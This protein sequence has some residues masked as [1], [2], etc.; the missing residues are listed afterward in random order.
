MRD[1]PLRVYADTSVF[2]GAF[3]EEFARASQEFFAQVRR[4]RFHLVTSAIVQREIEL[5]PAEVR[6]LFDEMAGQG[7][8]VVVTPE[9]IQLQQ[10]YIKTGIVTPKS[11]ADALHVAVATVSKCYLIVSWNFKHIVH[12]EKIPL[13]NAV[14]IL[15]KQ[16]EIAIYSP[17]GVIEDEDKDENV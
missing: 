5:A 3:D 6:N 7:E 12:F 9:A 13:Y 1:Q 8:I 14:N 10:A 15:N 16:Q 2:G 11:A 4:G 17:R